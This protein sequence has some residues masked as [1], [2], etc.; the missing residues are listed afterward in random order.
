MKISTICTN[1]TNCTTRL[2]WLYSIVGEVEDGHSSQRFDD[3]RKEESFEGVRLAHGVE[4]NLLR[5]S[6]WRVQV[7]ELPR[8]K[9]V[10]ERISRISKLSTHF[11]NRV[12]C[13]IGPF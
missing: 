9:S 7:E 3:S 8:H 6:V 2:I 12:S 11:A 4:E 5:E 13:W 10:L 1:C